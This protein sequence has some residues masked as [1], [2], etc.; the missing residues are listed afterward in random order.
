MPTITFSLKDMQKLVGKKVT[1][2]ELEDLVDYAKGE[3]KGHEGDEVEVNFDD[4]N[5]P[6]LWSV[7]GFARLLRG[8]LGKQS[9]LPKL[10]VK[11]SNEKII[12]D[13]S[14]GKVR[15]YIA[16][17]SAKGAAVD[18][19]LIK[20]VIQLQ[21]K[22][23]HSYG[24]RRKVVAIGVYSHK[25]IKFPVYYKATNPE[26][27]EFIPLEYKRKMTQQEILE[28]H[29]KGVEFKWILEGQK[30]YPIL[31]DSNDEVLSFPPII[32][33]NYSGK[34]EVGDRD[35]FF[36]ATGEDL[37]AVLL[38]TNIFAYA[39]AERGFDI[40][41]V[42]VQYG[43]KKIKC[44]FAF[45]DKIRIKRADVEKRL[46]IRLSEA[47]MKKLIGKARLG[48]SKGVVQIPDYRHDILHPVDIIEDIAIL[49]G[50]NKIPEHKLE[51]Y[52][53]GETFPMVEF[54]N[55]VRD[56]VSGMGYQEVFSAIL[57]NKELL[58][59]KMNVKDF[60]TVEIEEYMTENFS[61]VRSW[62]LP[63]LMGVLSKNKHVEYP[64]RLFEAG[65]VTKKKDLKDYRRLAMVTAHHEATFTEAKQVLDAVMRGVGAEY[66][67]E[68][69]EH[70]SFI[71]G[72][73][74]RV[75]VNGK[76]V[77]FIGE[78]HPK[79]LEN[80][81]LEVPVA[82]FELNLSDLKGSM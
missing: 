13:K 3:V 48:Y 59:D 24:R 76:G 23:C 11:K 46:G 42:E 35:L 56:I 44:P 26:S 62:I 33:S 21:E 75:M 57:S 28:V 16:A 8:I 31:M 7:E 25:K 79:V 41:E 39:F 74:G 19:Y 6:Y 38:A 15:P 47:E 30:K 22:L 78:L 67:I 36:E 29:P 45:K 53:V 43:K 81:G 49:Y 37:R 63:I 1:L 69:T 32:N 51:S 77:A 58:Y 2:K 66:T 27:V 20:Q 70:D 34:V 5:L 17:F 60:G 61:V 52:T 55:K 72:R 10:T 73:V 9:G 50:Y 40:H 65:L 54:S 64:Q 14:V 4:T 68:D 82:G 71:P 80:F 12:V 18:D